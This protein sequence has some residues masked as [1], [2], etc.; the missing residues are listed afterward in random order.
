MEQNKQKQISGRWKLLAVLAVCASPLIFSYLTYYVIKPGGRTNYGTLIDPREH[1]I[2]K[3][4]TT[5]LQ[6]KPVALEAWKGKWI[7]LQ[8]APGDC[9]Q[10]CKEQQVKIRQLRLM[11]GKG[12]ERIER[13]WLITDNAPLDIE[14]MKVIDGARFLRVKPEAVKAWLPVEQGSDV[15]DHLY[16]I[17]PLGNL[18]MRFPKNAEPNKV[19]KDIG[20]LLKASAVG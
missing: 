2:P 11:Q 6:G 17:D 7:M 18:M 13:V 5:D 1:P 20:K 14:L 4:D 12:M 9:Q 10:A 3:L 19:T 15:T 16:L 8:A